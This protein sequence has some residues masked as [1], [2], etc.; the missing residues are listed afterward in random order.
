MNHQEIKVDPLFDELFAGTNSP[1]K[2][3]GVSATKTVAE[4]AAV[5]DDRDLLSDHPVQGHR[6]CHF[7]IEWH[8]LRPVQRGVHQPHGLH[9]PLHQ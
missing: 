1:A 2:Y 3:I 5:G 6:P 4:L 9:H 7:D 8:G